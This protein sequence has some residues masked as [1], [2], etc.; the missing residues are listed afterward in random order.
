MK[1]KK[2]VHKLKFQKTIKNL[3]LAIRATGGKANVG[4]TKAFKNLTQRVLK[5]K[6][7]LKDLGEGRSGSP[8]AG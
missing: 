2:R 5:R 8:R 6:K 4:I 1:M 7:K 3:P